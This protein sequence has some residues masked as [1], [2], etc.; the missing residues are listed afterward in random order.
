MATYEIRYWEDVTEGD[1]LKPIVR[2]P[3]TSEDMVQFINATS[4]ALAFR[5]FVDYRHRHPG[6][7][8][9]DPDTGMWEDWMCSMLENRVAQWF[10]FPGAHDSG[11]Q[12]ICWLQSLV[13]NWA[14]DSGFLQYLD[15]KLKSPNLFGDTIWCRGKINKKYVKDD[16]HLLDIETYCVNQRGETSAE[17]YATMSLSS[18][19]SC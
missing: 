15:V 9:K 10:G 14:G 17:G 4:P 13:T 16:M 8:F 12:R 7:T 2:G 18:L 3:L 19:R 5:D 6:V 1:E 11:V